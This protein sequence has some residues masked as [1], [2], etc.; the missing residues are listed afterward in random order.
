ML[1]SVLPT[2]FGV[3]RISVSNLAPGERC[4]SSPF[5]PE[6][7]DSTGTVESMG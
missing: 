4:R 1:R 5:T 7:L 6:R 3:A 2:Y